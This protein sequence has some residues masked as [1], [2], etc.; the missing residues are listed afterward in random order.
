MQIVRISSDISRSTQLFFYNSIWSY[1]RFKLRYKR[2]PLPRATT[3]MNRL[4]H[5]NDAKIDTFAICLE[6]LSKRMEEIF[7]NFDKTVRFDRFNLLFLIRNTLLVSADVTLA[8]EQ[9]RNLMKF[10]LIKA[11]RFDLVPRVS[12][13]VRIS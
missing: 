10:A 3:P 7:A 12:L 2:S 13:D 6:S 1:Q 11:Y 5:S 8:R 9:F 4:I